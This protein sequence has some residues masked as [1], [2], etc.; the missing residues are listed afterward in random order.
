MQFKEKMSNKCSHCEIPERKL[1]SNDY[2]DKMKL[3]RRY[4]DEG[5][6][7]FIGGDSSL[8]SFEEA[9]SK[10]E[11]YIYYHYFECSCGT[12]IRT[13]VCIRSSVPIL[14]HINSLPSEIRKE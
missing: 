2:F 5:I 9:I 11:K 7:K 1:N 14:E 6:F 4:V 3:W 13:G 12:Y 10:E 8:E